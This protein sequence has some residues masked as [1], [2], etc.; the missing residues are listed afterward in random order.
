E[1]GETRFHS[2]K[3]GLGFVGEGS[4]VAVHDG[5]RCLATV[6]LVQRCFEEAERAGSAI[7]VVDCK[8]SVRWVEKEG[9]SPM[10]RG[11]IKLVQTP[12]VFLSRVLLEAF[13]GRDGAGFT[14]EATVVEAAGHVV[15][16]VEG[17]IHNIKITSPFDLLVAENILG[18][19]GSAASSSGNG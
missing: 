7:P 19:R 14:D 3:N 1:G 9:S 8:D 10:D 2:V 11:R 5:V 17:E 12:Q 6:G 16:L 18:I 4:V 15:H 13:E